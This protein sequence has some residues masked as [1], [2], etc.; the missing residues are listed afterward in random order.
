MRVIKVLIIVAVLVLAGVSGGWF[1]VTNKVADQINNEY[2]GK[3]FAVKGVD[4]SD[5]FITF[6]R[7]TPT[8]FPFKFAW[9]VTGWSEES[10]SAKISYKSPVIFGYDL[11]TQKVI[12]D[13]DGEIN[14]AYKPQ[15]AGFGAKLLINDYAIRV[16]LP[17][18]VSLMNTLKEL[19][20]PIQIVNHIGN[21][22][23]STGTVQVFDL[24]DNEKFYDKDYEHLKFTF[25]PKK[26]YKSLDDLMNNIPQ[27]YT[28][29]YVVKT[30]SINA[31]TRRLPVSLFYG[32]SSIPA[33]FDIKADV[34]VK[35]KANNIEEIQKGLDIKANAECTSRF[36]NI[37]SF[38]LDYKS[39]TTL[40]VGNMQ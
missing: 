31:R 10:R 15:K 37:P 29:N 9:K 16:N 33:G 24:V 18:T 1:Y 4:N 20:D 14:S 6:D 5:Y 13:Y 25:K 2:A 22:N 32:F 39:G 3:K 36:V 17:L 26:E 8:G 34:V 35:T 40:L 21:I 7:V 19:D 12:V 38:K 23:I 28:A 11:L 30:N 27:Y